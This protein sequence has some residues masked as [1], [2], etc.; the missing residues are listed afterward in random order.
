MGYE[1][2]NCGISSKSIIIDRWQI[3]GYEPIQAR[4]LAMLRLFV[5]AIPQ[6]R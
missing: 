1:S 2:R 6:N 3:N 4:M 5:K